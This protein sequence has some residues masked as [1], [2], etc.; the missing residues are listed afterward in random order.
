MVID[1]IWFG[2]LA[3]V[4]ATVLMVLRPLPVFGRKLSFKE[5]LEVCWVAWSVYMGAFVTYIG[6][7]I[8]LGLSRDAHAPAV[9]IAF[10][11]S[12]IAV[13]WLARKHTNWERAVAKS[14]FG[15]LTFT[16]VV[17]TTVLLANA[18]H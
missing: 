16:L 8:P 7:K 9:G 17:S 12:L 18:H 3:V 13:I 11:I 4:V 2:N 10:C 5:A 15:L 14:L 1:P 6:L